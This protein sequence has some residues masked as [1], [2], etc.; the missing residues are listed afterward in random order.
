M[1]FEIQHQP[2]F[3]TL[4]LA[5]G[6]GDS[7]LAQP[8]SMIAM[9]TGVVISAQTGA[10]MGGGITKGFKGVLS[11]ENF[12]TAVFRAKRP[13]QKLTLAPSYLG[14]IVP[15]D[16]K[17]D[18]GFYLTRGAFLACESGVTINMIY[19]GIK[20]LMAKK[21]LFYMHAT[22]QGVVFL[23]SYGAVVRRTL[24]DGEHFVV[25]NR[26]VIGFADTVQYKVVKATDSIKASLMSGEGLVNRYTGP[27]EILYQTRG[28]QQS[29][30]FL[31]SL[32]TSAT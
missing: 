4:E 5:L 8:G 17:P 25:D 23:S 1:Q 32:L 19:G 3:S 31:T 16:I 2:V 14:E 20:G 28:K 27:G 24:A 6:E 11:G 9:T 21:G 10:H 7:I 30:G 22:G 18:A 29:G 12:F 26:F 13:D 15:L